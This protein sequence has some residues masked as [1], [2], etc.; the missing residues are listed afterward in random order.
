MISYRRILALEVGILVLNHCGFVAFAQESKPAAP[1]QG[2]APQGAPAAKTASGSEAPKSKEGL[3]PPAEPSPAKLLEDQNKKYQSL[4]SFSRALNLLENMYVEEKVVTSDALLEKAIKGLVSNLDPHTTYLPPQQLKDLTTDTSGKF[5]GIGVVLS[6]QKGRLEIIEVMQDSPAFRAGLQ[7]GDLIFAV[8]RLVITAENVEE[9]LSR[10]K[11]LPGSSVEIEIIPAPEA[12]KAEAAVKAKT[13]FKPSTRKVKLTRETIR[14]KSVS[15]AKLSDGYAYARVSVF[16]E[17]SGEQLDK[18]LRFYEA[19]NGGKLDGLILDLRNNPGG[20]LDQAVRIT[21]LFIDSGIIVS[22]IGRDRARQDVEYAT[23]RTTHPNMPMVILVNEGSASASEIVAGALQDHERAIVMGTT[24]FGKGSVQSIVPLPNGGGLKITI[25]R[26]YTP[27]G[28]SIQ[29]K[30]IVP[31][32]MLPLPAAAAASNTN[33]SNAPGEEDRE[34]EKG[35][36]RKESDL[37]GHIEAADLKTL[38]NNGGFST[39]IEKWPLHLRNDPQIRTAFTYIKS[40]TR[41]QNSMSLNQK[42]GEKIVK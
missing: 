13:A 16:Q 5:G 14:T 12:A 11:G 2:Q 10:M 7:G 41:F 26:Y 22:T 15:H 6:Q 23:K 39:E 37:E 24:T 31:D 38:T 4:E 20:L 3:P 29:A 1:A 30:G 27:K 34:K 25:A 19:Q 40:W 35:R 17:E 42:S 18:A 21:D 32:I 8:D 33:K 36:Y 9:A 28:R